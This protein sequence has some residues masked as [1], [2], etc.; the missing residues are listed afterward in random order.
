MSE[1]SRRHILGLAAGAAAGAAMPAGSVAKAAPA[2]LVEQMFGSEF[3][4]LCH[5]PNIWK[6][7]IGIHGSPA[8]HCGSATSFATSTA[9]RGWSPRT[10]RPTTKT[11]ATLTS[12]KTP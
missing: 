12:P 10:R 1:L 3:R 4:V 5:A 2:T 7:S 6:S 11:C 9:M 8:V